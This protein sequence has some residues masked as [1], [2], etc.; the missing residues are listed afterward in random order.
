MGGWVDGW[1]GG[2]GWMDVDRQI[3]GW[4]DGWRPICLPIHLTAYPTHP[5]AGGR[6]SERCEP[7]GER[8]RATGL[9]GGGRRQ[10]ATG[11]LAG[12]RPGWG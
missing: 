11:R 9:P 8:R 4:M 10:L 5:P 3:G 2:Y 7:R 6:R 1:M 12:G